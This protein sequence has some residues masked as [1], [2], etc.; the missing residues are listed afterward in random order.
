MM[1]TYDYGIG[2]GY[3]LKVFITIFELLNIETIELSRAITIKSD[4]DFRKP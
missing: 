2:L 1:T 4:N 3:K